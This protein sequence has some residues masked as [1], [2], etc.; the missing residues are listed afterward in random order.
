MKKNLPV[1]LIIC[2]AVGIA[3]L[4]WFLLKGDRPPEPSPIP[5]QTLAVSGKEAS[6]AIASV[7]ASDP[8]L[9]ELASVL[10]SRD[11]D[12]I[13]RVAN[14]VRRK[15]M[16]DPAFM[17]TLGA[18]IGDEAR[19][20]AVREVA[21][22]ILGTI[23]SGEAERM[24]VEA[25]GR[26]SDVGLQR[27]LVNAIGSLKESE[28]ANCFGGMDNPSVVE[29]AS[30]LQVM[31]RTKITDP[32]AARA[33]LDLMKATGDSELRTDVARVLRLS[34][35]QELVRA[36]FMEAMRGSYEPRTIAEVGAALSGWAA[37]NAGGSAAERGKIVNLLIET[38]EK[39]EHSSLRFLSEGSLGALPF[40]KE[41]LARTTAVFQKSSDFDV[42]YWALSMLNRQMARADATEQ[43]TI[44]GI[45]METL[46]REKDGKLREVAVT[47]LG[48]MPGDAATGALIT[49]AQKDPE[50]NVRD[51]AIEALGARAF[52]ADVVEM[53]E[54][55]AKEDGNSTVRQTAEESLRKLRDRQPSL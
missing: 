47:G 27:C 25:L 15:A 49:A 51:A 6:R 7:S 43:E 38:A 3:L 46:G 53:L 42:R 22:L 8:L 2:G 29:H 35:D 11:A 18:V 9:D 30:G 52:R 16:G 33:L 48:E 41:E 17:R 37:E 40:S 12:E 4:G 32:A 50:W 23:Q 14:E 31:V 20:M 13:R 54:K 1:I 10:D 28:G 34:L 5:K 44:R 39:P 24:L 26:V 21:A 19:P 36:G 55:V 45:C